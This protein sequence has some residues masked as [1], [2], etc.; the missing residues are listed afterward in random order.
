MKDKTVMEV[1]ISAGAIGGIVYG[2]KNHKSFWTTAGF[3]ILFSFGG[4]VLAGTYY[5]IKN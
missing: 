4:A 2:M 1:L 5:A 3:A